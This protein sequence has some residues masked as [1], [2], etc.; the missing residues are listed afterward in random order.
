MLVAMASAQ[1]DISFW[2]SCIETHGLAPAG[3]LLCDR[4]RSSQMLVVALKFC[5]KVVFSKIS[6][7]ASGRLSK[8]AQRDLA[9]RCQRASVAARREQS[10]DVHNCIAPPVDP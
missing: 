1:Y 9:A 6:V 3:K 10:A 5:G 2:E 4:H 8:I 7:N